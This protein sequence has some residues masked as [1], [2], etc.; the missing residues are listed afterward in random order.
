MGY[1]ISHQVVGSVLIS[2][3]HNKINPENQYLKNSH[4]LKIKFKCEDIIYTLNTS[5]MYDLHVTLK[6]W[7]N[8]CV[9]YVLFYTL[10]TN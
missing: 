10:H 8:L 1:T 7:H 4:K 2:K 9:S 6:V 5:Y 3:V